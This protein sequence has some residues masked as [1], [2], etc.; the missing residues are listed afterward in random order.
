MLS[1]NS[2]SE[3][4]DEM[5]GEVKLRMQLSMQIAK[6]IAFLMAER[7]LTR[8]KFADE[9]GRRPSEITKWLSGHHNF[10]ISTLGRISAYF[11]EPIISVC[12]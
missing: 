2:L 4:I 11:G 3:L 7:G 5:P 6:R 9:L 8:K 1:D 12:D 10:T